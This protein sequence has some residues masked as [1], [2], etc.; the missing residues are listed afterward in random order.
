MT[1]TTVPIWPLDPNPPHERGIMDGMRRLLVCAAASAL[2]IAGCS[3]GSGSHETTRSTDAARSSGTTVVPTHTPGFVL[4][5]NRSTVVSA[6]RT[7][8]ISNAV[9]KASEDLV[10]DYVIRGTVD[11]LRT[12]R[13]GK[14]FSDLFG[15]DAV[16]ALAK[17]GN[18]RRTVTDLG[19]ARMSGPVRVRAKMHLTGLG[20]SNGNIVML[21]ASFKAA[22]RQGRLAIDRSGELMIGRGERGHWKIIGYNLRTRRAVGADASSTTSASTP[23]AS[24]PKGTP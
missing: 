10:R 18:D 14:G 12:G 1:W 11:V 15:P 7:A 2:V 8:H 3:G 24:A 22:I 13:L 6:G 17:A 4:T 9:T 20:D 23:P 16:A 5:A 19:S 21:S